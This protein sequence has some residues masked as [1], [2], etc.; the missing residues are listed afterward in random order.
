[1]YL[2]FGACNRNAREAALEYARIYP[3]RRHPTFRVFTRLDITLRETGQVFV[4][5]RQVGGRRRNNREEERVVNHFQQNPGTSCRQ[6]ERHLRKS[7]SSIHRIFKDT[8]H[9]PYPYTK[10]QQ[11]FPQDYPLR[12]QFCRWILQNGEE[13]SNILWTDE[14]LFTQEGMFNVHNEHYWDN[15]NP[16]V[17]RERGFQKKFKV[18]VWAGLLGARL[19]GPHIIEGTLNV[20][21][22]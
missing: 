13:L 15:E 20:S 2:A 18:N 5:H 14:S 1:M 11:F 3:D 16:Q 9:H 4:H 21:I 7:K 12:Q 19:I 6:A 22:S 8:G 17:F 10:V